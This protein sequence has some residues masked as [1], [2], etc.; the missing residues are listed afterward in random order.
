M[1]IVAGVALLLLAILFEVREH[2][3]RG[4]AGRGAARKQKSSGSLDGEVALLG[5]QGGSAARL[6]LWLA[7]FRNCFQVGTLSNYKFSGW[8]PNMRR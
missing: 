6:Q 5:R 3:Q 4:G 1:K 8:S 7:Q 2:G